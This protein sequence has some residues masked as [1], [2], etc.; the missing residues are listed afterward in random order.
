MEVLTR[1]TPE[2]KI[3]NEDEAS[4]ELLAVLKVHKA[5]GKYAELHSIGLI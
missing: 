2:M 4:P 3:E 1:E 5:A